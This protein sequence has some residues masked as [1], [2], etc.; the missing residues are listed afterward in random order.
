MQ[1]APTYPPAF[2]LFATLYNPKILKSYN[3][4]SDKR[5]LMNDLAAEK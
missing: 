3:P 2:E 1:F 4:S 5:K